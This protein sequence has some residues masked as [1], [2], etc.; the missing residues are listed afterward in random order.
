MGIKRFSGPDGYETYVDRLLTELGVVS[1]TL[2]VSGMI[3]SQQ[4]WFETPYLPTPASLA[5]LAAATTRH[6]VG[7]RVVWAV[8]G[9]SHRSSN[10]TDVMRG[11]ETQVAG[12]D[13]TEGGRTGTVL[14]PGT[15]SKWVTV[16]DG[17]IVAFA[18]YITGELFE[19]VSTHSIIGSVIDGDAPDHE[20]FEDGVTLGLAGPDQSGGLL[21]TLFSVRT[22]GLLEPS[23]RTGLASYLSGLL[24]GSEFCGASRHRNDSEPVLVVGEGGLVDTYRRGLALADIAATAAPPGAA[25]LGLQRIAQ[26]IGL[27]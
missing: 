5:D 25:G 2:L 22:R 11:E 23:S 9:V 19:L 20:A 8:P 3:T 17:S 4:G 12:T 24:I 21:S 27:I 7:N 6:D 16:A 1:S 26:R 15:H 13:A 10:G 14:L 18:T